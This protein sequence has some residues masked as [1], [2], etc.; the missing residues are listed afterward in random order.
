[1]W[2][3]CFYADKVYVY[4]LFDF[5]NKTTTSYSTVNN[6]FCKMKRTNSCK[7]DIILLDRGE[8]LK[9]RYNRD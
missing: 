4:L 2:F 6:N 8:Y 9:K 3:E 1:M 5:S 7:H